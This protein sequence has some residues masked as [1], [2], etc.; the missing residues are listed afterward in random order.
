MSNVAA[1][2]SP[3]KPNPSLLQ[4]VATA[5][6]A[7]AAL[8][9]AADLGVFTALGDGPKTAVE[10]A[11]SLGIPHAEPLRLV[12]EMCATS[13]LLQRD[14][15]RYSNTPTTDF[16]LVRGRPSYIGA[17]LAYAADLYPAW[18]TLTA[19]VRSGKA[20]LP[21]DPILGNDPAKTRHFVLAMHQRAKD[22]GSVLPLGVDLTGCRRLLDVG[23]GPGT[24][25]MRL[26]AKTPGLRSTV[27]D[28]PSVLAVTREIVESEGYAD[29][30]DLLPANYLTEDFGTGYDAVLLSG[31]MH[32][33]TAAN[34]RMLLRKAVAALNAGGQVIVSDVFFEDDLKV[35]PPFAVQFALHMMLSSD[36]GSAHARTEMTA[37][38]TAAGCTGV[39]ARPLPP[40]NPHT[41]IVG[42]KG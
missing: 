24:Y 40:P 35:S 17:G 22:I 33:E 10:V 39:T 16:F 29:R 8:F 6:R 14:G 9:A 37:W 13:A 19:L 38:M 4:Q 20:T 5:H 28:L 11:A 1:P 41:L 31:M 23:G 15:E 36:E 42:R 34:C 30:I 26:I 12:M 2:V 18:G 27:L 21:P 25:S 3:D 32:R 7:S